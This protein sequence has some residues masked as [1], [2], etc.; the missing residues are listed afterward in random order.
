MSSSNIYT[1]PLCS[2]VY[3]K[4]VKSAKGIHSHYVA[5][6][7]KEGNDRV[8]RNSKIRRREHAGSIQA[9]VV[10]DEYNRSPNKCSI[11]GCTL[12]YDQRKQ[13]FCSH[14]CA[15]KFNNSLRAKQVYA[16]SSAT[17]K[18]TL[19]SKPEFSKIKYN[20]CQR[21]S[22]PY[23]YSTANNSTPSFCSK[24]CFSANKA[25]KASAHFK[26]IGAGGVRRSKR[27]R[28]NGVLLGS[29]YEVKLAQILDNLSIEWTKPQKLYY[30]RP[31]GKTSSYTADLYLPKYKLYLDP[32]NDFLINNVNPGNG[33]KDL[34]KIAFVVEAN[35]VSVA[36]LNFASL[37]EASVLNLV[38]QV[39]FEPTVI[40]SC[41][42]SGF[43]HS[44]HCPVLRL[45]PID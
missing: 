33:I 37:N 30:V 43:D 16:K 22:K 23:W 14:S 28:Y 40:L 44:H 38:G 12:S 18:R 31:D 34:D 41:K 3:C 21:C 5:A 1:S 20:I 8:K 11:C 13:K 24:H 19:K 15:A 27:I 4:E 17:L 42:D 36:I 7:T 10:R 35:N 26:K 29:N 2:C 9:K 39:G 32:K 6:H 25:E 45:L